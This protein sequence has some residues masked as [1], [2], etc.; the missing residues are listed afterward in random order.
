VEGG[1]ERER[2]A[3]GET[4]AVE[5]HRERRRAGGGTEQGPGE[6]SA[7]LGFG[8]GWKRRT[9]MTQRVGPREDVRRC[10]VSRDGGVRG[11]G[12]AAREAD[13]RER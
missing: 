4:V 5:S 8:G 12:R 9:R 1:G 3:G 13:A 11:R 6:G 10:G 2:E 7:A